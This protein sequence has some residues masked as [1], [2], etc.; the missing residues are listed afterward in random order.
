[1]VPIVAADGLASP[2]TEQIIL[3]KVLQVLHGL[4]VLRGVDLQDDLRGTDTELYVRLE[5]LTLDE[6][7]RI[8][9]ALEQSYQLSVSYEVSVVYIESE[10]EPS[11][12]SPVQ[13]VLPE[14][15]LVVSAGG[16]DS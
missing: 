1:M 12:I 5:T 14:Y 15:S 2:E 7:S 13:V 10:Q 6:M 11:N 8:Y 16:D 4:P 3:G 9:D